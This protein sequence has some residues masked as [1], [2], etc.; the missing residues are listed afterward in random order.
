MPELPSLFRWRRSP[1]RQLV[2]PRSLFHG[3]FYLIVAFLEA[4]SPL[5][6]LGTPGQ[7]LLL[8]VHFLWRFFSTG[9]ACFGV[10]A[11]VTSAG[12]CLPLLPPLT[13]WERWRGS[14]GRG[15]RR[16]VV[17][18]LS[19]NLPPSPFYLM[20]S[21][22]CMLTH[23]SQTL[24]LTAWQGP[25][26]LLALLFIFLSFWCPFASWAKSLFSDG[27]SNA[28]LLVPCQCIVVPPHVL[29]RDLSFLSTYHLGRGFSVAV[30]MDS[31]W[32]LPSLLPPMSSS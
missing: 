10:S 19:T 17:S 16:V 15:H 4:A 22:V 24:A 2:L 28:C 1:W 27:F 3:R 5:L 23:L 9:F 11:W 30:V 26:R 14:S 13:F 8:L 12:F 29:L 20:G 18:L 31:K 6:L 32:L 7:G 25:C 21:D